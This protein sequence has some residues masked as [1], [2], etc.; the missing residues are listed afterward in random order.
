MTTEDAQMVP[1]PLGPV[2]RMVGRPVEKHAGFLAQIEAC[3]REVASWPEWMRQ[4][5]TAPAWMLGWDD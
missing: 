1:A 5:R 4:Q 3:R 2:E